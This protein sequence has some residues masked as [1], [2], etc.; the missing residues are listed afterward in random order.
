MTITREQEIWAMALW[1]DREHGEDAEQFIAGRVLHFESVDDPGGQNLW[2]Q[3]ARRYVEL[4]DALT[5]EP[6]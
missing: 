1:V 3:V 6:N 4:R 5:A 2:M